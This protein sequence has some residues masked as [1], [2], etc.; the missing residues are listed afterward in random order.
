M[1]S[2]I[3]LLSK[4]WKGSIPFSVFILCEDDPISSKIF[5]QCA[6][7]IDICDYLNGNKYPTKRL[8]FCPQRY[9]PPNDNEMSGKNSN[10]CKGWMDLKRDLE[11]SAHQAGNP[12]KADGSGTNINLRYFRCS[13]SRAMKSNAQV[14]NADN[15]H[16]GT[17]MVNNDKGNR[18]KGGQKAPRKINVTE[19]LHT[20]N[21]TF[22][23]RWD[24][25]GFYVY[26]ERRSGD[27]FHEHH[28]KPFHHES[29]PMPIRLIS[30]KMKETTRH[31]MDA[32]C[33]KGAG[34]NFLFCSMGC[35][36][37]R[38]KLAYLDCVGQNE[39]N[40]NTS[41][42]SSRM[43]QNFENADEIKFTTLSDVP[44]SELK[45]MKFEHP[46]GETLTISTTKGD[47]GV[48][49]N[50]C[51]DDDPLLHPLSQNAKKARLTR[52]ME[53]GQYLFMSIAWIVLPAF[54]LF[55]LCPEVIW[56][57]VTSHSNNKG[58]NL[59]TFSCRTSVDKQVIFLWIFIPNEQRISFRWVF[60]HAIPNLIPQWIRDRVLFIMKD[61]DP[62][63]RNEI[64][65]S[66]LRIFPKAKEGGCGWHIG[67]YLFILL[68]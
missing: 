22:T 58:F 25:F 39:G 31:V 35:Y 68:L 64:L 12:I 10:Q 30:D 9:P 26:L 62:Q 6:Q 38:L 28:S 59:L 32:T 53:K 4:P 11:I 42:D 37:N 43:L 46:P 48:L 56:C 34:R 65:Y 44:V 51:I 33:D 60:Q 47:D 5:D 61:G 29:V 40:T 50:K 19:K 52:S 20:C 21:F 16:R 14:V 3:S 41:D 57:D 13:K 45:D 63:Q 49:S 24:G 23:V 1:D 2:E 55:M 54:R 17:S 67:Q 18:R 36:F 7:E 66:L 15:P 27:P 8:Y